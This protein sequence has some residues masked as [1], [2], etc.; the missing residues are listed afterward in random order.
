MDPGLP[1]KEI[2]DLS[3]PIKSQGTPVFPGYPMPLKATMTTLDDTG[4][5]SYLW[6]FVEH[7]GTHVDSPG[8][9]ISGAPL[10]DKVP[11]STY[12]ARGAVLDLTSKQPKSSITKDDVTSRLKKA[13]LEGKVGRGW[14]LLLEMGWSAKAGTP[15]WLE[16]PELSVP[17]SEEIV[18]LGVNAVGLDSPSPD[19][20]PLPSHKVLLSRGIAIFEN[21]TNLDKVKGKDFIFVGAPLPLVDGSASPVRALALVR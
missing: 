19:Y 21:L 14:I 8:H 10:V 7:S 20:A 17:A 18:G 9:V 3:V 1:F 12:I 11:L 15:Q 6:M 4:W 16:Y 5:L 13:G 2:I